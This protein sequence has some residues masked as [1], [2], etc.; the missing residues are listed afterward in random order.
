VSRLGILFQASLI[1]E[2]K[3]KF[4]QSGAPYSGT[5]Y[6]EPHG[7]DHKN[8][9]SQ[10]NTLRGKHFSLLSLAIHDEE[11]KFYNTAT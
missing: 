5:L 9:I 10:R 1:F 3:A 6:T 4:Y 11:K 7:H 2:C 8:I